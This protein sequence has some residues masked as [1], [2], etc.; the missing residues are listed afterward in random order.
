MGVCAINILLYKAVNNK[1][2]HINT[3]KTH[4]GIIPLNIVNYSMAIDQSDF[5][6]VVVYNNIYLFVHNNVLVT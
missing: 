3:I 5:N 6:I 2:E 1:D 4:R